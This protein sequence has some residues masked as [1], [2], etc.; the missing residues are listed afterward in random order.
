MTNEE[1]VQIIPSELDPI[2]LSWVRWL[3][4]DRAVKDLVR[5]YR[6]GKI[7]VTLSSSGGRA[8][9]GPKITIW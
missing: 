9:L 5:Q 3:I 7:D 1:T 8:V 2:I 6:E 4:S